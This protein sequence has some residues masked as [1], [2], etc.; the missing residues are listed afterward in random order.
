MN[1]VEQAESDLS[2][3]LEDE[4]NGFGIPVVLVSPDNTRYGDNG[5]LI[6]Q[7]TDISFFIDPGTGVGVR[8]RIAEVTFRLS[9]LQ[10]IGASIPDKAGWF[11][12]VNDTGGQEWTWAVEISDVDRKL[13]IVKITVGLVKDGC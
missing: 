4:K 12:K 5:D 2:F 13:G 3:T 8:G 7:T 6:A 1:I 9:T 10:N 11:M